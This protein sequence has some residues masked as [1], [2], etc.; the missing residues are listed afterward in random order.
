MGL[1]Q[2]TEAADISFGDMVG[3]RS[4]WSEVIPEGVMD[5]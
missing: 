3:E 2:Y 5:Y 4:Q 1:K